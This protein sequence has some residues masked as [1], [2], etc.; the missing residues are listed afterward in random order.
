M[1]LDPAALRIMLKGTLRPINAQMNSMN[2]SLSGHLT[3]I[4]EM[5]G[6]L[7]AGVQQNTAAPNSMKADIQAHSARMGE[8][9]LKLQRQQQ[10]ADTEMEQV[11]GVASTY[12]ATTRLQ[13]LEASFA[14]LQ[15][16]MD[17]PLSDPWAA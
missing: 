7:P 14:E 11:D 17:Q 9:E 4:Q 10:G 2:I 13:S 3:A 12:S 5:D 8:R 6:R 1:A 15:R 16:K